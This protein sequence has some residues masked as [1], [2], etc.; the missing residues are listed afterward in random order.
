[1]NES[2]RSLYFWL[3]I[4]LIGLI[5]LATLSLNVENHF[6]QIASETFNPLPLI[7]YNSLVSLFFGIYISFVFIKKWSLNVN[8][9]LLC[10]VFIPSFL[11]SIS[12]PILAMLGNWEV[13]IS[14]IPYWI[15]SVS[16]LN[17]FGI[18]A[19][20]T[21]MLGIFSNQLRISDNEYKPSE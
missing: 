5:I 20:L 11:I 2:K 18:V 21:L 7:W 16:N 4:W 8:T 6:K 9:T 13:S 19:G 12:Y 17:L 15:I 1:M 3:I 14:F 10:F